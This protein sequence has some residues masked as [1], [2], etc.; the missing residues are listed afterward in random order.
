M[1]KYLTILLCLCLAA[2][3][4][5]KRK[6][7]DGAETPAVQVED[8]PQAIDAA[9]TESAETEGNVEEEV[10]VEALWVKRDAYSFPDLEHRIELSSFDAYACDFDQ[11]TYALD[12]GNMALALPTL[13]G[14][15]SFLVVNA[16]TMSPELA[17]KFPEIRSYKGKSADGK[18]SVR[19]DTN[20][21]GLFAEIIG[22]GTKHLISPILKG[23]KSYYAVYT[24]DA[25]PPSAPRDGSYR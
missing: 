19:L 12:Q 25:L 3:S 4:S 9:S 15:V 22:T 23:S 1:L 14:L 8:A 7:S 18:L 2:C 6:G 16:Q 5:S 24:E 11:L 13:D 21:E 20:E 10:D 17:A